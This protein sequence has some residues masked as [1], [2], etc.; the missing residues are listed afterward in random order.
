MLAPG[1]HTR[2]ANMLNLYLPKTEESEKAKVIRRKLSHGLGKN[3]ILHG[4]LVVNNQFAKSLF[5]D[6]TC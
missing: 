5:W 3:I 6:E 4:R 2:Y 1:Q